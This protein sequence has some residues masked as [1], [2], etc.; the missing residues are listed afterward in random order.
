[1]FA[2]HNKFSMN[3]I[4]NEY[5]VCQLLVPFLSTLEVWL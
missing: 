5:V 1:M 2:L 4:N 3:M